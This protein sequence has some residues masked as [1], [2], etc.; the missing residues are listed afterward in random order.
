MSLIFHKNQN[1]LG[2]IIIDNQYVL[3]Q[4]CSLDTFVYKNNYNKN[5]IFTYKNI[6]TL[7]II[8]YIITG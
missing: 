8:F 1:S 6:K 4:S 3:L 5:A 7:I 2:C